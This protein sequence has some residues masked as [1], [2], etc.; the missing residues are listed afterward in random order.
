M[1][2]GERAVLRYM[3]IE[4]RVRGILCCVCICK[5]EVKEGETEI[6]M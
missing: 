5:V 4:G 1:L 3:N 6:Y 2:D